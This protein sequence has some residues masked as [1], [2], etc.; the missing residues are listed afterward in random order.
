[1]RRLHHSE[2]PA[3]RIRAQRERSVS[4]CLPARDE[5]AT[6]GPIVEILMPLVETGVVDQV[7]VADDS[8]DA[9]A[10][11]AR[12]AGAEVH[13]QSALCPELGPV[14]GKG[15][16]MWRSLSVLHGD[17]VCFLDADSSSWAPTSP[18]AWW[19]RWRAAPASTSPRASTA[20]PSAPATR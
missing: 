3:A 15:D 5:A 10:E 19:G 4:I 6:I 11:I 20:A 8:T 13:S 1:M 17:V 7:V 16:A 9:T 14:H 12:A 2:F 18:A